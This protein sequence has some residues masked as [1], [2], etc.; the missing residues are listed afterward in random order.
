G[1]L[2]T[3]FDLREEKFD[4]AVSVRPDPR[5]HFLMWLI[6]ARKRVGFPIKGSGVFLHERL[7]EP[8]EKWHRVESYREIG[9]KLDVAGIENAEPRLEGGNKAE[10]IHDL[11]KAPGKPIVTAHLGAGQP[12]RRWPEKYWK[13]ILQQL[14]E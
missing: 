12:V 8:K 4:V 13:Q 14:R 10:R 7:S 2:K 11:L 3:I 6:G 5:D 1:L 9:R